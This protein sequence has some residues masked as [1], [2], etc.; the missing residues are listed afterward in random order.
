MWQ[1]F[2]WACKLGTVL[3]AADERLWR[4][5]GKFAWQT[6]GASSEYSADSIEWPVQVLLDGT[7]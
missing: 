7:G 2:Y 5:V 1:N 4:K 6:T 3:L